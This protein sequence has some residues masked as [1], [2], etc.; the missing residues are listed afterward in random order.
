MVTMEKTEQIM[1]A[2]LSILTL[3]LLMQSE[4]FLFSDSENS[5]WQTCCIFFSLI[6]EV[7][8]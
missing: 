7:V 4:I 3:V 2:L 5:Y 6:E 1:Y 8:N